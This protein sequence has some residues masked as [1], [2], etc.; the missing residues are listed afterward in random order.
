MPRSQ[1]CCSKWSLSS[2]LQCWC[3]FWF[4]IILHCHC[5]F[6]TCHCHYHAQ[7]SVVNWTQ[8]RTQH[9]SVFIILGRN[10]K[11][12]GFGS[13]KSMIE[14]VAISAKKFYIKWHHSPCRAIGFNPFDPWNIN[15]RA[16]T[17]YLNYSSLHQTRYNLDSGQVMVLKQCFDG[18]SD[19]EGVISTDTVGSILS[20]MAWK[21]RLS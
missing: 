10:G 2:F 6:C 19:S 8:L 14:N 13:F 7:F 15:M 5:H 18:F 17:Q 3:R 20:M 11:M 1:L 16:L 21:V 4:M 9:G 12:E